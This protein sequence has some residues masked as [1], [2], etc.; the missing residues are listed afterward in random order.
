MSAVERWTGLGPELQ[1][2]QGLLVSVRVGSSRV[3]RVAGVSGPVHNHL[4]LADWTPWD[5]T[6][7]ERTFVA[8]S[9]GVEVMSWAEAADLSPEAL[10]SALARNVV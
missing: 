9:A 2:T 7:H 4:L 5:D 6:L 10:A 3:V 1:T 8:G